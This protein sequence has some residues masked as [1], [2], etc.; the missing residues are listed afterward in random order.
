VQF[1]G[2][3]RPFI[4]NLLSEIQKPRPSKTSLNGAPSCEYS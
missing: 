3:L 4:Y 2:V 1:E